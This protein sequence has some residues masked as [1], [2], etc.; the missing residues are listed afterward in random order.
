M[1]TTDSEASSVDQP[2]ID[3][4]TLDR[5]MAQIVQQSRQPHRHAM[6]RHR[7]RHML[8]SP[9]TTVQGTTSRGDFLDHT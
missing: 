5:L 8:T 4:A 9:A 1:T 7:R 6:G 3:D 2:V